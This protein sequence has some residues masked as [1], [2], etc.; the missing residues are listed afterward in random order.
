MFKA[1]HF[2][3]TQG[4]YGGGIYGEYIS[5][6]D[7][8]KTL[9]LIKHAKSN[10]VLKLLEYYVNLY[11]A[12]YKDDRKITI[13]SM[14]SALFFNARQK[15][16]LVFHHYHPIAQDKF[17]F[18][19]QKWVYRNLL[20]NLEKI[21]VLV[22]VSQYWKEFFEKEKQSSRIKQIEVIYNPFNI[23]LYTMKKKE[24]HEEFKKK[25]GLSSSRPIVYIGNLQKEKGAV[26]TYEALKHLDI[27]M[28]ASGIAHIDLPIKH[29]QLSFDEY[30]T[31]L[32]ISTVSVLMSH[33][34]EGWNRIAH[35]SLLC[36]TPVVGTGYG[37]MGE[38]L[39]KAGQTICRDFTVLPKI[40]VEKLGNPVVTEETYHYVRSFDT[41]R[42]EEAW[43]K[44]L[45]NQ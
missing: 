40:V 29:L 28:V 31:L 33:I 5:K 37:G 13:R 6:L 15:N 7:S 32:Q 1:I 22:V 43:N 23:G 26:E 38:L 16:I 30:I 2:V 41:T 35:E 39:E 17:L 14:D 42:F 27:E 18:W 10:R 20:R 12:A 44:I 34:K 3:T 11:V 19:Y 45:D 24:M 9:P 21:D 36:G 25:F 8:V 4:R